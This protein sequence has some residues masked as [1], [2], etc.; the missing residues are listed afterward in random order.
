MCIFGVIEST[1]RVFARCIFG[2]GGLSPRGE[3]TLPRHIPSGIRMELAKLVRAKTRCKAV[4]TGAY[5]IQEIK[6]LILK[7]S[8]TMNNFRLSS[9]S[10]SL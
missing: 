2:G 4:Y 6:A 9:Y 1:L 3:G 10:G 8:Y 7:L 5:Y